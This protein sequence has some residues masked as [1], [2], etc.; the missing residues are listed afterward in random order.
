MDI[1]HE[2]ASEKANRY[3]AIALVCLSIA[4]V[5]FSVGIFSANP[6]TVFGL[7]FLGLGIIAVL[8][9]YVFFALYSH[10]SKKQ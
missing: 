3:G 9:S 10:F 4:L 1:H 6:E 5:C 2:S 8:S 7:I